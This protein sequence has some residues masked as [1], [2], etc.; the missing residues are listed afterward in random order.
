MPTTAR[1]FVQRNKEAPAYWQIGN[2]WQAM[3]TGVQTD[4]SFTLLDQIVTSGGGGGP[5][6]HTHTQDEGLYVV[7]GKCTFNAGGN[8]G[9]SAPAGTFVAV[10]RLTEHSF[11][12][13]EP[14]TQLLNFYLPA[15]FEMLLIGIAHPADA[16]VPPPPGVGLPPPGLVKKLAAQYGQEG[17]LG[18]PFVDK[19]GPDNMATKPTPGATL[20]PFTAVAK[21]VPNYWCQ[22]GLWSVLA[23]SEATGNSYCLYEQ[24]LPKGPGAAPH[25]FAGMDEVFYLLEGEMTFLLGD[26]VE[27][28][29]AQSLVFIPRGMVHGYRVDSEK[30]RVLNL[31]TPGDFDKLL[32]VIADKA[33]K[34]QLP[35]T[36]E[37]KKIDRKLEANVMK[38]IGMTKVA[39]AD[40]LS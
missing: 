13:D 25:T 9:L 26:R 16:N 2:L 30:A 12:V 18:M 29:V 38:D 32:P 20:F 33:L 15:G 11:T 27:K 3:A 10:P 14:N 17:I 35:E 37:E 36:L 34:H 24:L 40:P 22:G 6:T 19:A 5:C 31:H 8:D 28:A 4:N 1:A 23:S 21:E 7:T 39:V